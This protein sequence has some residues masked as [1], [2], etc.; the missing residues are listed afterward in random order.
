MLSSAPRAR[1]SRPRPRRPRSRRRSRGPDTNFTA[2][3]VDGAAPDVGEFD[4]DRARR[5]ALVVGA[6]AGGARAFVRLERQHDRHRVR[7]C[8]YGPPRAPEPLPLLGLEPRGRGGARPRSQHEVGAVGDVDD[9]KAPVLARPR[10]VE[11][12]APGLAL[13]DGLAGP[14]RAL[15]PRRVITARGRH[16]ST[17]TPATGLASR[18]TTVPTTSRTGSS[19]RRT[20]AGARP[21]SPAESVGT[22]ARPRPTPGSRASSDPSPRLPQHPTK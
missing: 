6:L 21:A 13:V 14:P 22:K 17:R 11:R 18:P 5:G 19:R 20:W 4:V 9:P 15:G 7:L 8:R 16:S 3:H 1:R 2:P 12:V 10:D